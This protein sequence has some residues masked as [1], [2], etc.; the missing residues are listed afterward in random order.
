MSPWFYEEKLRNAIK[1][2]ELRHQAI[3]LADA[4]ESMPLQTEANLVQALAYLYVGDS[5]AYTLAVWEDIQKNSPFTA[6]P[7]R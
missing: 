2:I 4:V 5:L 6:L 3:E 7:I 1:R